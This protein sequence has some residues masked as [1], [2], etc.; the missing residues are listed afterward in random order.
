MF[1][2]SPGPRFAL[3]VGTQNKLGKFVLTKHNVLDALANR[4]GA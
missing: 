2:K 1:K 4:H 3:Y